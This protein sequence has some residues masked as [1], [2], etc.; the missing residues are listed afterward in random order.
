MTLYVRHPDVTPY[1]SITYRKPRHRRIT[2]PAVIRE[3][4]A[5]AREPSYSDFFT[6]AEPRLLPALS[7]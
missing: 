1:R 4:T 3:P 7:A 6:A 5:P 2:W